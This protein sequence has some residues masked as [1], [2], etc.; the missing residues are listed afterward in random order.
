VCGKIT[1]GKNEIH[2]YIQEEKNEGRFQQ[3]VLLHVFDY[4]IQK[5]M[6]RIKKQVTG[7][8]PII[9]KCNRQNLLNDHFQTDI[10]ASDDENC[11]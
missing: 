3:R 5:G 2:T 7:D 10:T 11:C 9:L 6:Q 1:P 4:P 8:V